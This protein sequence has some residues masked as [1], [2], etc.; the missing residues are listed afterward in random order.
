MTDHSQLAKD[1]ALQPLDLLARAALAHYDVPQQ[2]VLTL[3]NLS[4]NAT[5][6]VTAP[7]GRRWA[8]RLHRPG[9]HSVAAIAS[10]LAWATAL[11]R[12][13]AATTPVPVA[14]R[15]GE[16]IQHVQHTKA[17]PRHAVLF[18]WEEG[19]E[20]QIS[21][22]LKTAFEVLGSAAARMHAHVKTWQRPPWFTRFTWDFQTALGDESPHWGRWRDGMG[23]DP[24]SE[25]LFTRT[26]SLIATR[27]AAYGKGAQRFGLVHGDL[28]LAN[29]LVD[30]ETVKV[31]DF[32]DCGFSWFMYDAATPVSFLRTR[33]AGAELLH[34]WKMGYRRIA[35]RLPPPMKPRSPPL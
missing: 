28:R 23:L 5:Y 34:H 29:L 6:G 10:E 30:G 7:D 33:A 25:A 4:E 17:E 13:G 27:L 2:S 21:D 3:I 15:D 14:G 20:P 16:W 24:S 8:L 18:L 1:D 11:R 12:D 35:P 32:D 31:I 19:R 26:A 9:Y 22:D